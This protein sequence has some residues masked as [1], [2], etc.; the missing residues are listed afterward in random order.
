MENYITLTSPEEIYDDLRTKIDK[1][2]SEITHNEENIESQL[3][4]Q[5]ISK[6][7]EILSVQQNLITRQIKELEDNAEWK[8]FTVAF[9]GETNAGKSTIIEILRILFEEPTKLDMQNKFDQYKA[10]YDL[11]ELKYEYLQSETVNVKDKI[12]EN[13][14]I[15]YNINKEYKELLDNS[16]IELD[17]LL[18]ENEKKIIKFDLENTQKLEGYN[19]QIAILL[20]KIKYKKRMMSW[21]MKVLYFFKKSE[22]ERELEILNLELLHIQTK[23]DY[24]RKSIVA[25]LKQKYLSREAESIAIQAKYVESKEQ[26][27]TI[28]S[29]LEE[30]Q[31]NI[32][33][34]IQFFMKRLEGLYEYEDGQII[35]DGRSDYTRKSKEFIFNI[36]G[37][38]VK[39]IDVP[40]IE[41]NES[42]VEEEVSNA[43]KK[44]HAVFF[45]TSKDAAPNEGTLEKIKKHL[46]AQTEVWTIY[47][48][49]VTSARVLKGELIKNEDERSVLDELNHLM[50][51]TLGQNYKNSIVIAGLAAFYAV[52]RSLVFSGDKYRGQAKFLDK[53]NRDDLK[54]RSGLERFYAH[55]TDK[56]VGD[57]P[58]KI[59]ASNFNKVNHVLLQ[60]I[61]ALNIVGR[62]FT[63]LR[64]DFDKQ[65]VVTKQEIDSDQLDLIQQLKNMIENKIGDFKRST[66][67]KVYQEIDKDISNDDFK[68]I[69]KVEVEKNLKITSN[70]LVSGFQ[71]QIIEFDGNLKK[72]LEKLSSRLSS[73]QRNF[74]PD[75]KDF[76]QKINLDFDINSGINKLGLLG[77]GVGIAATMWWNPAG[78]IAISLTVAGL[79]FSFAKAI[80]SFFDSDFKKSEQRKSTD[81]NLSNIEK[82]LKKAAVKNLKEIENKIESSIFSFKNELNNPSKQITQIILDITQSSDSFKVLSENITIA[83]GVK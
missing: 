5:S 30:Q 47:N 35:G 65:I 10:K 73:I 55:I 20:E 9:F 36:A 7:R 15:L 8:Y 66:R 76:N 21:L 78:W 45:V 28:I 27:S 12:L 54:E 49:P 44:A 62:D 79:I 57:A 40:G 41:G 83:Y 63:Q 56:M 4:S 59:Q 24:Q 1:I 80:W 51:K 23:L 61:D 58:Y 19:V 71:D 33:S 81:K 70:H 42:L 18:E 29:N 50:N 34:E 31:R 2:I 67:D 46:T 22:E 75:F 17:N 43:V 3:A 68:K 13:K 60:T 26:Q 11:D 82:E 37:T 16:K 14:D 32:D 52:A 25:Q 74:T 69:L 6:S 38:T 72:R 64:E 39:L 48:K 53:F 77:V